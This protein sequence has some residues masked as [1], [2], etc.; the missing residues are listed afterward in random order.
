MSTTFN[1]DEAMQKINLLIE[2]LQD[3]KIKMGDLEKKV[4]KARDL[5]LACEEELKRIEDKLEGS[6]EKQVRD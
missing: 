3:P 4:E 1:Y 2:E 6:T 5:I